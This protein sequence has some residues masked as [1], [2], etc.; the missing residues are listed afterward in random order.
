MTDTNASATSPDAN[1]ANAK[2]KSTMNNYSFPT[3][4]LKK[5][6][7]DSSRTPLVD[8]WEPL[9][10]DYQPTARVLDR[11]DHELNEVH[12]GI[13][14]GGQKRRIHVAL[15]AGADLIQTMSTPGVWSAQ[16]LDHILNH[17]GAF[18]IERAGT[19]IDDALA[20][21][22]QWKDNI[23]VIPQL[24]QNDISSTKVRLFLKREMSVQYLIPHPVV[25]YI[26]EN[27]LY[28]DDGVSS[29]HEKEGKGKAVALPERS[30]STA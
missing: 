27:A 20:S 3:Q 18:I 28:G 6:L 4:R 29:A 15:L 12:G 30:G 26:E 17:Y 11:F 14:V 25:Q 2:P 23:H 21:L 5:V 8:A 10:S 24:I 19:D 9:Q 1:A 22:Q 16:D 7:N 13:Q